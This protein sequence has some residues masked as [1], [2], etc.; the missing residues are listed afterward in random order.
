MILNL[1]RALISSSVGNKLLRHGLLLLAWL[2]VWYL[3]ALVEYTAHASVWFPAAGLT[4][5]ALFLLG[6]T[7]VP[8]LM[9]AAIWVTMQTASDYHIQLTQFNLLKAGLLFGIAHILPYY[10][11]SKFLRW[12]HFSKKLSLPQFIISFLVTAAV[13]SLITTFCVLIALIGSNMMPADDF[14]RTWL[15]FWIGDMAGIVILTPL[16]TGLLSKLFKHAKFNLKDLVD[17]QLIGPSDH[18]YFKIIGCI[19]LVMASMLLAKLSGA[20]VSAFAIFFLVIPHMWIACTESPLFSF[21]SLTLTSLIIVFLVH[22]LGLMDYVLVYQFAINVIAANTMFG[23]AIPA[24]I[25][26]NQY[27]RNMAFTDSL[28]QVASRDHIIQQGL[29][30]LRRS[31]WEQRPLCLIVFD[32]DHFKHIND[33]YGHSVGDMALKHITETAQYS[34]RP[35]D[36]LGRFGGDEFI[37]LLPDTEAEAALMVAERILQRA[38]QVKIPSGETLTVSIG[39]AQMKQDDDFDALFERADKALY[40]AKRTGRNCIFTE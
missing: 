24:L 2:A 29:L 12:L 11:A 20:E 14:Y 10:L 33:E 19:L 4:L 16:F 9:I 28:T 22:L 15:P 31:Q 5:A 17:S 37:V 1:H 34:L 13:A 40:Q 35:S 36:S 30:E 7:A 38:R 6:I 23:V 18:Y 27:L 8:T 3:S 26:D 39:I 21:L 32:I 25:K